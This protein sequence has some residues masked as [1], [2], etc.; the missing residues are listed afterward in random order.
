MGLS[1]TSTPLSQTPQ[2]QVLFLGP[3]NSLGSHDLLL[4]PYILSLFLLPSNFSLFQACLGISIN[5]R[6]FCCT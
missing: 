4:W 5:S 6:C 3:N 1:K 2:N